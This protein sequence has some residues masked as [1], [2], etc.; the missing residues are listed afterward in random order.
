MLYAQDTMK[1]DDNNEVSIPLNWRADQP[2]P[3]ASNVFH[4]QKTPTN[5]VV[6]TFGYAAPMIFGEPDQQ[7]TQL[8]SLVLNGLTAETVARV[9]LSVSAAQQLLKALSTELKTK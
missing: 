1:K 7:N 2:V 9:C 8:E 4:M 6:V 3:T 5:E